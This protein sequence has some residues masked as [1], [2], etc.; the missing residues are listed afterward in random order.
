MKTIKIT[1]ALIVVLLLTVSVVK[2]DSITSNEDTPTYKAYSPKDMLATD[3]KKLK[4]ET[5]A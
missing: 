4:M 3:R 2:T 5:Q 1:L